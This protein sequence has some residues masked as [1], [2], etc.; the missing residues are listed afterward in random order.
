[1]TIQI[2]GDILLSNNMKVIKHLHA[3]ETGLSE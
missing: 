2:L 3:F 1:M